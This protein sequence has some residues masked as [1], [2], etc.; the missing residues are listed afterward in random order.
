MILCILI[1]VVTRL[2]ISITVAA[3]LSDL[4]YRSRIPIILWCNRHFYSV[5]F[6]SI[7][8]SQNLFIALAVALY[9][10]NGFCCWL[11]Y[12]KWLTCTG[13]ITGHNNAAKS[14]IIQTHYALSIILKRY[15]LYRLFVRT[16]YS[17]YITFWKFNISE[18]TNVMQKNLWYYCSRA[19]TQFR[20][21]ISKYSFNYTHCYM[22]CM[23]MC[24]CS[25]LHLANKITFL[26]K[27]INMWIKK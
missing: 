18:I 17:R 14:I 23:C 4:F 2:K 25:P 20:V 27:E 24:M 5:F 8:I 11:R 19:F 16:C 21:Q 13:W 12:I 22:C 6:L 7:S 3:A 9:N 26:L 15:P 10:W 1:A